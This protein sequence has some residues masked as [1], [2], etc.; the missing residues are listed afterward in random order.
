MAVDYY[1]GV[2]WGPRATSAKQLSEGLT[3]VLRDLAQRD[4][5]LA[6]WNAGTEDGIG[7]VLQ[8]D[9]GAIATRLLGTPNS[10]QVAFNF[11]SGA[12]ETSGSMIG[13]VGHTGPFNRNR[14]VLRFRRQIAEFPP[15]DSA[16]GMME[17]F[18][19]AFEPEWATL[20]PV[21]WTLPDALGV[22][23]TV[24]WMYYENRPLLG[25][26]KHPTAARPLGPGTMIVTGDGVFDMQDPSQTARVVEAATEL[27]KLGFLRP[28]R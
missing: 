24:G 21:D 27:S 12:K 22:R 1:L 9:A 5:F 7:A 15:L 17:S 25:P 26:W 13:V 18:V 6:H 23:N 16:R 28:K 4:P 19:S 14:I 20:A 3:A 11:Y 10:S 2:Y 8:L